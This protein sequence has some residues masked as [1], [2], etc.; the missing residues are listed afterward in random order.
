M[1]ILVSIFF[2][3][4]NHWL[5]FGQFNPDAGLVTPF[6]ANATINTSSGNNKAFITDRNTNTYWESENPLPVNYIKRDDLNLF[7]SKNSF[8]AS[9]NINYAVDGDINTK[10]TLQPQPLT[11]RFKKPEFIYFLSIKY[12][13]EKTITLSITLASDSIKTIT[14]KPEKNYQLQKIALE[15]KIISITLTN[16]RPYNLF[17]IAGLYKPPVEYVLLDLNKPRPVGQIA[18]RALND[19]QVSKIEVLGGNNKSTLHKLFTFNPTAIPL[20]PYL[21]N[22]EKNIRYIKIVFHLPMADYYK[23]KLWEVDVYN[24]YGPFGKPPDAKPA[25]HTYGESFGINAFWG[26]GYNVYADQIPKDKGPGAFRELC[27]LVRN[28]H[29][30]DWDIKT[31]G[32]SPDY[33]NME[34]REGTLATP[35]LDWDREYR[36]W[37][38]EGFN[39]DATLLFNNNLFP[40]T[41][42]SD[43]YRESF[44]LGKSF[45]THFVKNKNFINQIEVGNEPWGYNAGTYQQIL[46]GFADGAHETAKITILPCAVQA[47]DPFPDANHYIKRYL[48]KNNLQK[49]D[50]LNTHFYNYIFD[51]NGIQTAINPEDPRAEIWAV[52]NLIRYR[53]VNLPGKEIFVTEFGYDSDGG[54][55]TCTHSVCIPEKLQ[56]IYGVRSALI[57]QRLG[58]RQFYWYYFANVAY[59]SYLHNRSGLTSSSN[60]G[61]KKKES[62]YAF[63]KLFQ[64]LNEYRFK[65]IVSENQTLYAYLFTDRMNNKKMIVWIPTYTNHFRHQW[66]TIPGGYSVKEITPVTDDPPIQ[67]KGNKVFLSGNPVILK[68]IE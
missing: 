68:I 36:Q 37:K 7:K 52:N 39:I 49:I 66:V 57:L 41:L 46:S 12:Q 3:L 21:L 47:Y 17:E 30:L 34:A 2:L 18:I 50:G 29:R 61:F 24:Y 1:K 20:I 14:L 19:K 31:P 27:S 23:V 16:S 32:Q 4:F 64:Q 40:D 44:N 58:V 11:I 43:P 53:D 45:V 67:I 38:K 28:Y 55:E 51:K 6:T 63:K 56:A 8:V 54:G 10:V 13:T 5:L 26:W 35:W 60:A 65:K 42:W 33:E 62:F 15:K 48:N 9:Q 59:N 22:S 25:R